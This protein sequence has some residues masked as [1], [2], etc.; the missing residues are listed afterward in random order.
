[1]SAT[2]ARP[3]LLVATNNPGKLEEYRS[4]LRDL[5]LEITSL[6]DEEIDL[7]PEETGSTFE[8]NAILKARAFARRSG[9]TALADDSGL[10]IDQ[11]DGAPGVLSARYAG[12]GRG[13]DVRRYELVLHQLA[14]VPR[15][16][17]TARFR[18]VIAIATPDG[19]VE[20]AEGTING[21]IAY[22]PRGEGGFGYDP[23]FYIP[24]FDGTMAELPAETKNRI[25]H[26]A[27]AAQAALPIILRLVKHNA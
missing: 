8:E 16:E 5:P 1:M 7:E 6:R 20:T 11:L 13:E 2:N 24:E 27:R 15:T 9:L 18:C 17:R 21:I 22:E 10:E 14:E 4:L 23:I 25:S 12:T 26:R 3:E 19:Q